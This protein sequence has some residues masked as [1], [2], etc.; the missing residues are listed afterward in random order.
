MPVLID[1]SQSMRLFSPGESVLPAT[2]RLEAWNARHADPGHRFAFYRFGD[3]LRI[4]PDDAHI[5]FSDRR[6]FLPEAA[7]EPALRRS[8]AVVLISDG[9][10][11][12]ATPPAENFADKS[13][14]FMPLPAIRPAPFIRMELAPLPPSSPAD[15]ALV[16][17]MAIEGWAATATTLVVAAIENNRTVAQRTA[18]LP[19][20][21]FRLSLPLPLPPQSPGRHL[22]RFTV[23]AADIGRCSVYALHTALPGHF[24]WSATAATSSL[25]ERFVKLAFEGDPDFLELRPDS[26]DLPDLAIAFAADPQSASMGGRLK[27]GGSVLRIG[28]FPGAHTLSPPGEITF[29]GPSDAASGRVLGPDLDLTRLPPPLR[30]FANPL[31]PPDPSAV[32]LSACIKPQS[33]GHLDTI[34]V[35]FESREAGHRALICAAAGIWQWDFAPLAQT[36][37][38]EQALAFSRTLVTVTRDMLTDG[39]SDRLL[40]YPAGTPDEIDSLSLRILFP[41]DLA[42]PSNVRL[43]CSF[44]SVSSR[45]DTALSFIAAGGSHQS[46]HFKP[47]PAGRYLLT[48]K[49]FAGDRQLSF[50]DSLAID[51]DRSELSVSEQNMALLREIAQPLPDINDTAAIASLFTAAQASAGRVKETIPVQRD[52]PLLLIILGLLAV[53]WGA[54]RR[55]RLD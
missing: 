30:F 47:L 33:G 5:A 8:T 10:W 34:P 48:A 35:I 7:H 16:P 12:N 40:L 19:H 15:S 42:I 27:P 4:A 55:M 41:A 54:R 14:W 6:S 24:T 38:E 23:S 28:C 52:W 29:K 45:F 2:R 49:G 20:G 39:L 44:R 11:S 26:R 43:S 9:N 32:I 17:T 21:R 25:D 31:S 3:S 18:P 13:V 37:A 53:E 46:L 50:V 51:P 1:V 22:Y 36:G